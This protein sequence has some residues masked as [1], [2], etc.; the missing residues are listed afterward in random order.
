[1]YLNKEFT[2]PVK[3]ELF[4]ASN[5]DSLDNKENNRKKLRNVAHQITSR[6]S[7]QTIEVTGFFNDELLDLT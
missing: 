3:V 7:K 2:C 1:M 4:E 5:N 6:F